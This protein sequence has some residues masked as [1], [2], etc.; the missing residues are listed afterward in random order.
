MYVCCCYRLFL[1]FYVKKLYK[2]YVY[3]NKIR[4]VVGEGQRGLEINKMMMFEFLGLICLK[5]L[6]ILVIFVDWVY[7]EVD[8][9]MEIRV[10]EFYQRVFLEENIFGKEE[11]IRKREWVEGEVEL[12]CGYNEV[13]IILWG[14]LKLR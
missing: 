3:I 2:N 4:L 12:L 1:L 10:Q 8:F 9:E 7:R 6:D 5:Y 14:D 13:L 11:K